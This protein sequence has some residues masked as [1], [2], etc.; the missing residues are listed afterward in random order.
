MAL[1]TLQ[2]IF[3]D[4]FPAYEQSHALP[5][6]VRTAARAIMQCRTAALGGHI[7]ACP[8]GHVARVW[9]N[10]CRHRSCPQCA[11]LQTERW[12]A[13]QQARLLA[14]DHYHVIFT[15][16]HELNP[17]WLA[18]VPVM[19][20]LLF[21]AVRDTLGT[22]LADPKYLGAQP[23][24]L[25]ALHT[26]SQTL[27]LHP[28]LHCLV[29][30]G[31]LTPAGQWVAVRHGFL[32]PARVVM[33]VFRG[34]MVDAIRRTLARGELALPEPMGPQQWLNLLNR[35]G[36]PTKTKWNVRIM[37]RYRHGAGVVTYLARYLRGGPIKNG[38]LVAYDGDCFTFTYRARQE[39]ADAGP[40]SPQQMTLPVAAF[41]QRWLLHVPVPQTRVV[42]SYGL[43][44][45]A[46]TEALAH[47]RAALGQPPV[48]PPPALDWQTVCA[49][50]GE[51][52]PERCP[53]CG[54]LLVCTDVIP[55]GGAPPL[56]RAGERAA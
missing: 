24:I 20:T 48:E 37:E 33:A 49:Q 6:H 35:L 16:P 7:Q 31:G 8:D 53:T 43:Y 28:H 45:H 13:L 39:E 56:V 44:H 1:V 55:R 27:V 38:R 12:L 41:L 29:T 51:A 34:K 47:C 4:A 14:C 18:N 32:L 52:H 40:A 19:T 5:A 42:R 22:L 30:G 10:S 15:L 50:R 46:H 11:Y 2:T 26:W 25:A 21:Q 54:Q 23:G 9:Y 17:L 3:Q 36:H